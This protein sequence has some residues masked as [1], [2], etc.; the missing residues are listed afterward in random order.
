MLPKHPE[1]DLSVANI[2][3][4]IHV[5]IKNDVDAQ[6]NIGINHQFRQ[7]TH[8]IDAT[9]LSVLESITCNYFIEQNVFGSISF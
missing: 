4:K 7:T 8:D 5:Y 1:K 2:A 6:Y 3:I 9:I